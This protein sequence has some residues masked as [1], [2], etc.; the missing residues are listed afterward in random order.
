MDTLFRKTTVDNMTLGQASGS[1]AAV[2]YVGSLSCLL[3]NSLLQSKPKYTLEMPKNPTSTIST[4]RLKKIAGYIRANH[5]C[6]NYFHTIDKN[7]NE[8][9]FTK[10]N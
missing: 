4:Y 6:N 9:W 5:E 10:Q 2:K 3:R 1:K 8:F 7:G